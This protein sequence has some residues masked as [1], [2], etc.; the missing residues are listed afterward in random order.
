MDISSTET[1]PAMDTKP[2]VIIFIFIF[3][4]IFFLQNFIYKH[5]RVDSENIQKN[6]KHEK[7]LQDIKLICQNLFMSTIDYL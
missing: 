2:M 4:I 7:N 3:L 5:A 6:K 1:K